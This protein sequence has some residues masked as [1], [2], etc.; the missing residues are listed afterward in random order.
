[1]NRFVFVFPVAAK[2]V[3]VWKEKAV[4]K[5]A[6]AQERERR[7]RDKACS[8]AGCPPGKPYSKP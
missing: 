2:M 3:Q 8:D 5:E 7:E 4:E 6:K 1:M